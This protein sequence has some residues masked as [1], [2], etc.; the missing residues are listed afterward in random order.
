MFTS[1]N[2]LLDL[3]YYYYIQI[4]IHRVSELVDVVLHV[5]NGAKFGVEKV[6]GGQNICNGC[7]SVGNVKNFEKQAQPSKG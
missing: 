4:D 1:N 6:N 3:G 7:A 5:V 2:L